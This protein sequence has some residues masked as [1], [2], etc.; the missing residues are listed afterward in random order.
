MSSRRF[1]RRTRRTFGS[2]DRED[3]RE[4]A[5]DLDTEFGERERLTSYCARDERPTGIRAEALHLAR[6]DAERHA[7]LAR[8]CCHR[9]VPW[10][11]NLMSFY[12]LYAAGV[13][14]FI[15]RPELLT[16]WQASIGRGS[17]SSEGAVE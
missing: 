6:E 10:D 15:P 1:F 11:C 2:A 12:E 13:P 5:L 17:N 16:K 8:G 9:V 7:K 14:L 4:L 3:S